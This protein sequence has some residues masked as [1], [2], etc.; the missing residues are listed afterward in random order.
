MVSGTY[1]GVPPWHTPRRDEECYR[2]SKFA[3]ARVFARGGHAGWSGRDTTCFLFA[4]HV[5]S[6]PLRKGRFLTEQDGSANVAIIN[7]TMAKTAADSR[8]AAHE[9][10]ERV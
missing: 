4:L 7:E 5:M 6:V 1:A 10:K 9:E 2:I 8:R 3:T